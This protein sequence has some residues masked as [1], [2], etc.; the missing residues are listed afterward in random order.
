[1]IAKKIPKQSG[2]GDNFER[3]GRYIAAAD[4][5]GEKLRNCWFGNCNAGA[6][7][8]DLEVALIEIEATRMMPPESDG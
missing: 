6:G 5:P 8:E 2:I 4:H 7:I 3:L 1:M